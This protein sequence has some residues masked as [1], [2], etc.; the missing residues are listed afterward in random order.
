MGDYFSTRLGLTSPAKIEVDRE[1]RRPLTPK[2]WNED[3]GRLDVRSGFGMNVTAA[4]GDPGHA[5]SGQRRLFDPRW[6]IRKLEPRE[7]RVR[8]YQSR[9]RG[10]TSLQ[11]LSIMRAQTFTGGSGKSANVEGLY[12][13][14]KTGNRQQVGPAW[15]GAISNTKQVSVL[16]L[17][18]PDDWRACRPSATFSC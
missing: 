9:V 10:K 4:G 13:G 3:A 8:G 18:V 17:G 11:M 16:R 14:G 12:V 6:T 15:R 5:A 2:V 1:R 7:P